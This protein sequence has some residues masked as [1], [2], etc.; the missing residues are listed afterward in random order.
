MPTLQQ[1]IIEKFLDELSKRKDFPPEKVA[2]L[3]ALFAAG[4]KPK[5]EDFAAIF[6]KPAGGDLT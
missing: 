4:K 5:V 1:S 2:E 3:R 6:S